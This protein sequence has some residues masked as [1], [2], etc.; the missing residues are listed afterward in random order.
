M[1][2]TGGLMALCRALHS[3]KFAAK[4]GQTDVAFVRPLLTPHLL[5]YVVVLR[6]FR[7]GMGRDPRDGQLGIYLGT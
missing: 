3:I 6:T 7:R 2:G 4:S 5:T 1:I